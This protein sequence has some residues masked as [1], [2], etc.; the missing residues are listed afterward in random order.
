MYKE[1][2]FKLIHFSDFFQTIIL[3]DIQE[4][5]GEAIAEKLNSEFGK[6]RAIFLPCDVTKNSEFDGR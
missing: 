3:V 2:I 5:E 6:K 1:I 4:T